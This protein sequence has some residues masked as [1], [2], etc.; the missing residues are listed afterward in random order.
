MA[1]QAIPMYQGED[2]SQQ[3]SYFS[4]EDQT[5]PLEITQAIMDVRNSD[6]LLLARFEVGN[7]PGLG[8][9]TVTITSPGV[10][11]L[12]MAYPWTAQ[13]PAGSY[14]I[15]IF[16]DIAGGG[17]QAITKRGVLKLV[18]TPRITVDEEVSP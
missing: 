1:T 8:L 7:T 2:F 15:D 18:V 13:I 4:D 6:G 10:L 9:G 3:L 12:S 14:A 17:R 16:A 5:V 11:V